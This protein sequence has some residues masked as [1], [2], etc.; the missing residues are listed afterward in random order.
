[1]TFQ[2]NGGK[3]MSKIQGSSMTNALGFNEREVGLIGLRAALAHLQRAGVVVDMAN[4]D[5]A[6]ALVV[7]LPGMVVTRTHEG[8][9]RIE[10]RAIGA[11][12]TA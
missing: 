5:E 9:R 7:T 2:S 10:L 3:S 11:G 12:V 8:K 1:M 4:I 6:G